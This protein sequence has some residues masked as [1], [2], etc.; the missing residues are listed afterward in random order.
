MSGIW[1]FNVH[2][3]WED[4]VSMLLGVLIGFSPW[5]AEQQDNPAVTGNALLVGLLILGFA[6]LTYVSLQRWEETGEIALGLWLV[7]SP[8]IFDYAEAGMLQYWH[9]ILGAIVA[10]LAALELWQDWTLSDKEL[11]QHGQQ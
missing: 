6:Q 10:L 3:S 7:A 9:F 11:A 5:L 1:F 2:R 8:F 4:W